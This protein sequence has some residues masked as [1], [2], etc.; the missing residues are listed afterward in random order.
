MAP[1]DSRFVREWRRKA[2]R[3]AMAAFLGVITLGEHVAQARQQPV[4]PSNPDASSAA[5][6]PQESPAPYSRETND[7]PAPR[8]T[9][10]A[11]VEVDLSRQQLVVVDDSGQV[12]K[13]LR[14]SSGNGKLFTS[15]GWTRR[16][17]TPTGRFTVLRKIP[18]WRKSALGLL[19]YPIYITGG[20]AIHGSRSVPR[21]PA[22]HGC[23]RI[24]MSEAKKFSEMT[25]LGTVV[26]VY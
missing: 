12:V 3:L 19:Y 14:I 11:H 17:I 4:E 21:R 16:A 26:L 24:P 18:G 1:E 2:G 22:S 8:E 13:T 7:E 25:P 10:Y 20:V 6:P 5:P 23:I 15:E 9:G